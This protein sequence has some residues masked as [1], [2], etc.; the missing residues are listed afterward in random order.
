MVRSG[1]GGP[2]IDSPEQLVVAIVLIAIV[3]VVWYWKVAS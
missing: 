3:A 1:G 2:N